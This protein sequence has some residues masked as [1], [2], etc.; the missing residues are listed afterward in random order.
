[1]DSAGLRSCPAR[2]PERLRHNVPV[3]ARVVHIQRVGVHRGIGRS[4]RPLHLHHRHELIEIVLR[5]LR[6]II[7]RLGHAR[8]IS[9]L[10]PTVSGDSE[11]KNHIAAGC[12]RNRAGI[13]NAHTSAGTAAPIT[14]GRWRNAAHLVITELRDIAIDNGAAVSNRNDRRSGGRAAHISDLC[15]LAIAAVPRSGARRPRVRLVIANRVDRCRA[16]MR[17]GQLHQVPGQ[18]GRHCDLEWACQCVRA[19]SQRNRVLLVNHAGMRQ[20]AIGPDVRRRVGRAQLH[21]CGGP[22]PRRGGR[23]TGKASRRRR[24]IVADRASDPAAPRTTRIAQIA[25]PRCGNTRTRRARRHRYQ[26]IVRVPCSDSNTRSGAASSCGSRD[27][28]CRHTGVFLNA[29]VVVCL[30]VKMRCHRGQRRAVSTDEDRRARTR[31]IANLCVGEKVRTGDV[32][33]HVVDRV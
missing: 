8:L 16:R 12:C 33:H 21:P 27:S 22:R 30:T 6:G 10:R 20:V 2:R 25:S 32:S 29:Q 13:Q 24:R 18:S 17:D 4:R 15:N 9:V 23:S 19:G 7:V 26:P 1:M 5:D 3:Q 14:A 28:N 11:G 31:A